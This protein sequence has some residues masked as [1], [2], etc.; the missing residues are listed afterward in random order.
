MSF[1]VVIPAAGSGIRMG[2]PVPKT[3]L[4]IERREGDLLRKKTILRWSVERFACR[5]DCGD[6]IVCAP[7]KWRERFDAELA[8]IRGVSIIDGGST[9]QESVSL[10]AEFLAGSRRVSFDYPVLVHDAAR[11]CISDAV[12]DAV[13]AGVQTHGAVTAAIRVSDSVCRVDAAG[14]VSGYV[15]REGLYAVQTPQGFLLGDLI[16][17]HREAKDAGIIAADDAGLVA[18]FKPVRV[19]PGDPG[20]IKITEPRDMDIF[21][22]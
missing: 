19:V 15:E 7:P 12:I 6:I 22:K 13:L 3:L 8:G 5:S 9:R 14:A 18:R 4:Q 11:C 16:R 1:V 10:G 21:S 17:A 20:N 2:A